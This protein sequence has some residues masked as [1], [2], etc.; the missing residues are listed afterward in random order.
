MSNN[1]PGAK[2]MISLDTRLKGHAVLLRPSMIKFEGSTSL[3]IEFCGAALRPLPMFLNRQLIKILEDM[4][5]EDSWFLDLQTQEV[6]NL[7]RVT[8]TAANAAKFLKAQTIGEVMHLSFLIKRLTAMGLEFRN[9]RFLRDVLGMFNPAAEISSL[10]SG[11][12][13]PPCHILV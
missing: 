11:I 2:G 6:E 1:L 13:T 9:D 3:D 7:R 8:A 12:P 5:V 10:T 4:G